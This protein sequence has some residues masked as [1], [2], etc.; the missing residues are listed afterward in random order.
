MLPFVFVAK[1]DPNDQVKE[2]FSNAWDE[3]VG[4]SRAISLYLKEIV[5]LCLTYLDSPQ[6]VLK[7][8]SARAIADA[9]TAVTSLETTI[10][11]E[12]AQVLWPALEK[13][14]GGKTWEGK[15][16]VLKAFVKFVES[17]KPYWESHPDVA[18]AII[19]VS[20]ATRSCNRYHH[21][22]RVADYH[23]LISIDCG[24]L[25]DIF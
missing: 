12:A 15:E 2:Q 19:K 14:Q 17:A 6:W 9:V 23:V 25:I 10:S 16:D 7:H 20:P 1:H 8:T 4:G 21:R 24:W 11:A 13:A 22:L 5:E 18:S 3:T